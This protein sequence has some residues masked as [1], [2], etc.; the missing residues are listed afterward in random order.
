MSTLE[1]HDFDSR[2][3]DDAGMIALQQWEEE[4]PAMPEAMRKRIYQYLVRY[5]FVEGSPFSIGAFENGRLCAFLLAAPASH[6]E[7]ELADRWI[8]ERLYTSEEKRFFQEYKAYI[9]GNQNCECSYALPG[10]IALL[11]FASIRKG[12]GRLL[13]AEF[14]R[15]C[16]QHHIPSMLLWTD[17]TCDFEYYYR[18]GFI[19]CAKIPTNPTLYGQALTTY[20]FRKSISAS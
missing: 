7:C 8:S 14:E 20:L 13:L 4:V 2:Y 1:I 5:Y 18:N 15:R 17:E 10:E 12:A 16:L 6:R 19:E 9:E 3:F 11:L